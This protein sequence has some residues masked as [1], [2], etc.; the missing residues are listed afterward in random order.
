MEIDNV[1]SGE[2]EEH[3]PEVRE[4]LDNQADWP[5]ILPRLLKYAAAK[6]MNFRLLGIVDLDP[7]D[8]VS[9]AITLAYS[10]NRNWNKEVYPD[11]IDFLISVIGSIVNHKIKHYYKF[12]KGALLLDDTSDKTP[13]L[14]SLSSQNP[15]AIVTEKDNLLNLQ[16]AIYEAVAGD[17]EAGMV[18]LCIESE[19]TR[20][21]EIA[22]ETGYEVKQVNNILKRLRRKIL[23]LKYL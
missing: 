21:R 17:E 1:N 13:E 8:L 14:V 7:M 23:N 6:T 4:E 11:P 22:E 15:E 12:K 19:K 3:N 20:P 5:E 9:E 16:K 10:G 18:L 2:H